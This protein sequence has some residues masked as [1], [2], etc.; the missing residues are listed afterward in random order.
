MSDPEIPFI[1]TRMNDEDRRVLSH[2]MAI[3]DVLEN[4]CPPSVIEWNR[5]I[6][7]EVAERRQAEADKLI[8]QD[9]QRKPKPS[10]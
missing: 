9:H 5:A 3:A 8:R 4:D 7:R 6:D 1:E 10:T 2:L